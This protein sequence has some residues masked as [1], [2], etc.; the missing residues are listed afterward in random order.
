MESHQASDPKTEIAH[1]AKCASVFLSGYRGPEKEQIPFVLLSVLAEETA[2]RIDE[3]VPLENVTFDAQELAVLCREAAPIKGPAK[4]KESTW[5][6]KNWKE[7]EKLLLETET[8][9]ASLAQEEGIKHLPRLD[10]QQS[11]GGPRQRSQYRLLARPLPEVSHETRYKVP[12]GGLRYAIERRRKVP[13]T[14]A[15]ALRQP[16]LQNHSTGGPSDAHGLV[17]SRLAS[18]LAPSDP[19]G[20][21]S[22]GSGL[23]RGPVWIVDACTWIFLVLR[24]S[25]QRERLACGGIALSVAALQ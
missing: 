25:V 13:W 6:S 21:R 10:K 15:V 4:G 16:S 3:G 8:F 23:L 5:V 7:L 11:R 19:Q 1:A 17:S 22:H 14:D 18:P 20:F 9:L 12:F 24:A 2:A